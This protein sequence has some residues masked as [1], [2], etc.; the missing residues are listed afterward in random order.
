M[1]KGE[2]ADA[3]TVMDKGLA[4]HFRTGCYA[5]FGSQKARNSMIVPT[6]RQ[7]WPQT[8]TAYN[9]YQLFMQQDVGAVRGLENSQV[10]AL[11]IIDIVSSPLGF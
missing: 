8:A 7:E 9:K 4:I 2:R 3:G 6:T 5:A 10:V 11:T 1:C